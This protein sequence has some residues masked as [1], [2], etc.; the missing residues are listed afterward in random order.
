MPL[1]TPGDRNSVSLAPGHTAA[2]AAPLLFP[3]EHLRQS[4]S[5]AFSHFPLVS[6]YH[7]CPYKC[8]TKCQGRSDKD[9]SRQPFQCVRASWRTATGALENS[10][11]QITYSTEELHLCGIVNSSNV[12]Q[13]KTKCEV[14][15]SHNV[16]IIHMPVSIY[17]PNTLAK[18]ILLSAT[19][20][21]L[22]CKWRKLHCDHFS[23]V[24]YCRNCYTNGKRSGLGKA[25]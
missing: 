2:A 16:T 25:I 21:F 10:N 20:M 13:T 6:H 8:A 7:S 4:T 17:G 19:K 3:Y 18:P 1:E 15:L 23:D 24:Y 9:C 22:S 11:S 14:R 5:L 12:D